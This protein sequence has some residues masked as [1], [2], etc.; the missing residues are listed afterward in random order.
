[1]LRPAVFFAFFGVLIESNRREVMRRDIIT[2]NARRRAAPI[3]DPMTI[4]AMAPLESES[5]E[6]DVSSMMAPSKPV[7]EE[8]TSKLELLGL[9]EVVDENWSTAELDE[10]PAMIPSAVDDDGDADELN[11]RELDCDAAVLLTSTKPVELLSIRLAELDDASN[12]TEELASIAPDE[13][14]FATSDELESIDPEPD[15]LSTEADDEMTS[16]VLDVSVADDVCAAML[17]ETE[18]GVELDAA[19][20]EPEEGPDGKLVDGLS[21]ALELSCIKPVD[22]STKPVE[23][24]SMAETD[25]EE[26]IG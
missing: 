2:A 26:P 14:L 25:D 18:N 8:S 15:E 3:N 21:A 11:A 19:A 5:D 4:P 16:A 7:D 9:N 24:M 22:E 10:L 17:D 1:M 12:A 20:A 6:D 23:L 13:E